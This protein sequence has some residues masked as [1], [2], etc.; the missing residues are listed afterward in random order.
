MRLPEDEWNAGIEFLT[1][2]GHIIDDKRQEFIGLSDV[3]GL[4]M[5]TI[6]INNQAYTPMAVFKESGAWRQSDTSW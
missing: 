5:Q 3:L 6:A 4:S 1:A 2:S